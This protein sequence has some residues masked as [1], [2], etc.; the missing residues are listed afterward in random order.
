[1]SCHPVAA[2]ASIIEETCVLL[3]LVPYIR[4]ALLSLSTT[5]AASVVAASVVAAGALAAARLCTCKSEQ[6][7]LLNDVIIITGKPESGKRKREESD[8]SQI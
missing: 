4:S 7:Q 2:A 1:M 3:F 5:L 6:L 8:A